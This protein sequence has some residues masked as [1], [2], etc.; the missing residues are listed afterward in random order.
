LRVAALATLFALTLGLGAGWILARHKFAGRELLDAIFSLPWFFLRQSSDI[1]C[2]FFLG[3]EALS[4][5]CSSGSP[6]S[7]SFLTWQAAVVAAT[8]S[9]LSPGLFARLAQLLKA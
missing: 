4:A 7:G 6:A 2:S 1:T 8:G 5:S 3:R 9:R